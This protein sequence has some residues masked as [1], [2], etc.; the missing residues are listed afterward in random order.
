MHELE[1]RFV[2]NLI[3][4]HCV[5]TLKHEFLDSNIVLIQ[6]V[7]HCLAELIELL[8]RNKVVKKFAEL[9]DHDIA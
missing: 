4:L 1:Q 3:V 8:L 9:L 2:G 7:L 5:K 6:K